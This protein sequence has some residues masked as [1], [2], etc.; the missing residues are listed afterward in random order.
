MEMIHL[1]WVI[2]AACLVAIFF[3][4]FHPRRHRNIKPKGNRTGS[5]IN[6]KKQRIKDH[7]N[8]QSPT[9]VMRFRN[10]E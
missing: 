4:P 1:F 2:V 5:R 6:D 8:N 7:R 10:G 3:I 9:G